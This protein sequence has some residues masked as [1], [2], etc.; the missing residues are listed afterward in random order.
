MFINFTSV[1]ATFSIQNFYLQWAIL[2]LLQCYF[3][4]SRKTEFFFLSNTVYTKN[5][6]LLWILG[7]HIPYQKKEGYQ[8]T[9]YTNFVANSDG[10]KHVYIVLQCTGTVWLLYAASLWKLALV[11]TSVKPDK[12]ANCAHTQ[13]HELCHPHKID[14]VAQKCARCVD[15]QR[16]S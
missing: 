15:L 5:T 2:T 6:S 13:T 4:L 7:G 14:C 16:A 1:Y 10:E 8:S 3:Y 9:V 12:Y 11:F